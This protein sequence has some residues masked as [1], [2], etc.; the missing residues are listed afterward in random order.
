MSGDHS[1]CLVSHSE[2]W[3]SAIGMSV[4][5]LVAGGI[6]PDIDCDNSAVLIRVTH[7]VNKV[8]DYKDN[9]IAHK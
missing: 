9:K 1:Q 5:T 3:C 7:F 8:K 2:A 6:S 4:Q